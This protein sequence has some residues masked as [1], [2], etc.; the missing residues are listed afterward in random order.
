MTLT[1][2]IKVFFRQPLKTPKLLTI[3][4]ATKKENQIENTQSQYLPE[5]CKLVSCNSAEI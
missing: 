4:L 2:T 1:K 3:N 5:R